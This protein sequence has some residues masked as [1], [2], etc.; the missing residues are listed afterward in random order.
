MAAS[1]RL[2]LSVVAAVLQF[3]LLGVVGLDGNAKFSGKSSCP[4]LQ[5]MEDLPKLAE[6]D[7]SA[8]P[9]DV[10]LTEYGLGCEKHDSGTEHCENSD[11]GSWCDSQWCFVDPTNC[12]MPHVHSLDFPHS[13]RFYSYTTCGFI[14][15]WKREPNVTMKGKVLQAVVMNSHRGY[16]GTIC[17]DDGQCYGTVVDLVKYLGLAHHELNVR[18]DFSL[19]V[20]WKGLSFSFSSSVLSHF[21]NMYTMFYVSFAT[22]ITVP[23][24]IYNR[25]LVYKPFQDNK[26]H[27]NHGACVYATGK[28]RMRK[29][30]KCHPIPTAATYRLCCETL[31]GASAVD[32]CIGAFTKNRH[33]TAV[34]HCKYKFI[35][36]TVVV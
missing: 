18:M 22:K 19:F 2:S 16:Q 36:K 8:G 32:L 28:L 6:E 23:E 30:F 11:S 7:F 5:K 35:V 25:S 17:K 31:K 12:E 1:L 33:R 21:N 20:L 4:C 24:E 29:L 3:Q 9:H 14:N 34:S 13:M 26:E 27:P 10:D 15:N